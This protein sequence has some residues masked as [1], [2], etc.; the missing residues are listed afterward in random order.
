MASRF[1]VFARNIPAI[2]PLTFSGHGWCTN[3]Q[4]GLS[5]AKGGGG[6]GQCLGDGGLAL[7]LADFSLLNHLD[8]APYCQA[9]T[10]L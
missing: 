9:K 4:I 8:R 1:L 2:Y 6:K 10:N 3:G 5:G 7:A